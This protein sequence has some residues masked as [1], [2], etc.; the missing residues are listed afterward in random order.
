M[1]EAAVTA[2][3]EADSTLTE[4]NAAVIQSR[5]TLLFPGHF[6]CD[7]VDPDVIDILFKRDLQKAAFAVREQLSD[8]LGGEAVA[9]LIAGVEDRFWTSRTENAIALAELSALQVERDKVESRVRRNSALIPGIAEQIHFAEAVPS[10][11]AEKFRS[12]ASILYPLSCFPIFGFIAAWFMMNKVEA[13]AS[14]FSSS[15]RVYTELKVGTAITNARYKKINTYVFINIISALV[16]ARIKERLV[17]CSTGDAL[18]LESDR[19]AVGD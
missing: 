14:A 15:N 9:S 7:I 10:Q 11:N 5:D 12:L 1:A 18:A 3:A 16:F 19:T 4:M 13:F 17:E 8:S 6:A 2:Q